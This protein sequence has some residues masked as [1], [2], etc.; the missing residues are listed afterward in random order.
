[1][2]GGMVC[3]LCVQYVIICPI[4]K[5]YHLDTTTKLRFGLQVKLQL[6]AVLSHTR[7]H[8]DSCRSARC[9]FSL[10]VI[11]RAGL[12]GMILLTDCNVADDFLHR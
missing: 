7:I 6:S 5:S 12:F 10:G 11:V 1:M 4:F 8:P 9:R 2:S 3:L